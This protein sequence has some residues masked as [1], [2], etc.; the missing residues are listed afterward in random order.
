[1]FIALASIPNSV[2]Y[3]MFVGTSFKGMNTE[4]EIMAFPVISIYRERVHN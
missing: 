2:A 1:M 3:S 4:I